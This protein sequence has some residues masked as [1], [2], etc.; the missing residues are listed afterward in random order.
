MKFKL[1][2]HENPLN[3]RLYYLIKYYY[4]IK[5]AQNTAIK[6]VLSITSEKTTIYNLIYDSSSPPHYWY[7]NIEHSPLKSRSL[8][9][10]STLYTHFCARG[11][12]SSA[13]INHIIA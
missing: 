11:R 3:L 5:I 4:Y 12:V 10:I 13:N 8:H 9:S 6:Y 2:N 1:K 7:Y